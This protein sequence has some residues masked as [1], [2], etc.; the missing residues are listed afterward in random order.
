MAKVAGGGLL[1]VPPHSSTPPSQLPLVQF[2]PP[3]LSKEHPVR[4]HTSPDHPAG[5]LMLMVWL[6]LKATPLSVSSG[7]TGGPAI[8]GQILVVHLFC[9]V[10]TA[11]SP[12]E[13]IA[14]CNVSFFVSGTLGYCNLGEGD[15]AYGKTQTLDVLV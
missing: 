12:P 3:P 13:V 9:K 5:A 6:G 15:F 1:E 8:P 14:K 11:A 2:T 4:A 10:K 7:F